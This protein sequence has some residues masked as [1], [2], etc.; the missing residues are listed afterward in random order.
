MR[1]I[2]V[3]NS[4]GGCGKTTIATNL[5]TRYAALGYATALFDYDPQGSSTAWLQ[6]RPED[7]PSIHGVSATPA[8]RSGVTRAWQLRVPPQTQRVVIDTP[9]GLL[10][11][12]FNEQL[13]GVDLI[14][15]PVQPSAIDTHAAADFIRD[16]LIINKVSP[17]Q[18]RLA[19]IANRIR[20]NTIGFQNLERFL[21]SLKIPVI[22]RLRDTQNY[23]H[24]AEQGLG[25]LELEGTRARYESRAW[26]RILHWLERPSDALAPHPNE[27]A[28]LIT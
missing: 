13:R 17:R 18:Q 25:V 6:R 14:L 5:A 9:A 10:R 15:I 24:A 21:A 8:H 23:V 12:D 20:T 16:L 3:L 27:L 22:A 28:D 7:R 11:P 4:K 1:R 2:I 19:I 26:E